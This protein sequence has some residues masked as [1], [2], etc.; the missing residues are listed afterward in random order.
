MR[1]VRLRLLVLALLPLV[2]LLPLLL[3]VTMLRWIGKY[4]ELLFAKVASDLR[5]AEQYFGRIEAT[6]AAEVAALAQSVRFA[7]AR[8]AGG[9][10]LA[11]FLAAEQAALGLDF[12]VYADPA[13]GSLPPALRRAAAATAESGA[14]AGLAVFEAGDL[15][16]MSPAL[17]DQAV[18]PLVPTEAARSLGRETETRGLVLLAAQ[19]DAGRDEVLVGGRLLNRN[20]GVIDRMNA[21]IYPGGAAPDSRTGTTTL[22][23]DDVRIS[24]NVRLFAGARALGTRVSEAV[25]RKVMQQG[26]P[27]LDR[28]FVVNDWYISGYVP[29]A[30]ITGTRV[31]MLYTGFLEAPFTAQR[32]TTILSLIGA[33]L[34]VLGLTIPVFLRLARGVFAPLEKMTATMERAEKGAL[35]ARI[36]PVGTRDEIGAVARHLD[37]LLDQVQERDDALRNYAENLNSLVETRT[38][39][40]REANRKLESTFAQLVM[41][42]KL[43]SIGEI[44]AGVAH[45]IN[46]PVAV[47]QGNLEILRMSLSAE[48]QAALKTELDLIDQQTHRINIIVGKLLNFTRPGEM[49]DLATLA[50]PQAAVSD[51]LVLVAA[52]LRNQ[53]IEVVR[54]HA[55]APPIRIVETE[56]QQV[57]VNLMIN[58]AQAM[59]GGGTLTIET[60]PEARGGVPGSRILLR[61]TGPG[62]P[63]ER[64]GSIF[65]PFY[66]SKPAEGTGLGLSISQSLIARADGVITAGSEEGQG[67]EF[68]IWCPAGD[69]S[70]HPPV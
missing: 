41:S 50:D 61:D 64:L 48:D 44:T 1:S 17:A 23:L 49:S 47:I 35:G 28:A 59:A 45:E 33:F 51:A 52:D 10:V 9:G 27:W 24:T 8:A 3:G 53:G 70:R 38:A 57:L 66:T 6:Q 13:D 68:K 14:K 43:A 29:L 15:S 31:G 34:A 12:L 21:L 65:D 30:D 2:V 46:N 56:L 60:G 62:I 5:V 37:R 63:P 54:R 42:E 69:I 55:P 19:A 16:R 26:Q 58:A 36:G 32:N 25:W 4:D 22:F 39:E 7:R 67:A 40:L 20:L 18:L 11:D